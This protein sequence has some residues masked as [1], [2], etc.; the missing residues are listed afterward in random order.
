MGGLLQ[1]AVCCVVRLVGR[2]TKLCLLTLYELFFLPSTFVDLLAV[3]QR[4]D[5]KKS[6]FFSFIRHV[7][8]R[9]WVCIAVC[10]VARGIL[11]GSM[12]GIALVKT[13]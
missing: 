11:S 1:F 5:N 2:C 6:R 8:G 9:K 13:P 3:E 12:H 7:W 10:I 4:Q